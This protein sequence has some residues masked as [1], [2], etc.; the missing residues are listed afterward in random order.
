MPNRKSTVRAAGP[1]PSH[2]EDIRPLI[3]DQQAC[4]DFARSS[5]MEWI[6]ANGT[7]AFAMGTVAGVNTRGYH[8]LLLTTLDPPV[9]RYVLLSR[10]EEEIEIAGVRYSLGVSQHPGV[11]APTGFQ[12]LRQFRLD[13]FPVWTY[14]AGAATVTKQ[15]FMVENR[16]SIVL[17]YT[18]STK[19]KLSIRPLLAFRE[20]HALAHKSDNWNEHV[21]VEAN[22]FRLRPYSNLPELRVYHGGGHFEPEP[23]WSLNNEYLLELERGMDFLEDLYSPGA[24]VFDMEPDR[25]VWI[26]ATTEELP[27]IDD[28]TVA[29]LLERERSRRMGDGEHPFI[30]RLTAAADQFQ[31]NRADGRPTLLAGF[32]WFADW[33]RDSMISIPGLLISRGLLKQA[34]RIVEAFLHHLKQGLIPNRFAEMGHKPEYDTA[35]ATLWMFYAVWIY[36]KAGGDDAFI[37]ETF[38][39][40]VKEILDWHKR[41]T[42][43]N[44]HVDPSDSL[45]FAGQQGMHLTWMDAKTGDRVWTPRMGKPVEIQALWYNALKMTESWARK[46][47]DQ[48]YGIAIGTLAGE[49]LNNF[50]AKFWNA[51]RNC[52][53][54]VVDPSGVPDPKLRPNQ[55]FAVSLPFPLLDRDQQIAVVK[56]VQK[57]LLTPVGLR[58]LEPA[59]PDYKPRYAGDL[60]ARDSAYHQGTVWPYLIGPF[61][62]AYLNAF[63]RGEDSVNYCRRLISRFEPELYVNGLGTINEIYD[64]DPPHLPRG[65]VGQMWSVAEIL[66]A[67]KELDSLG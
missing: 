27:Q 55:I 24:V 37:R 22:S 50:R 12:Y 56:V 38:Y 43:F 9:D 46:Y 20:Y 49:V 26:L 45:L 15:F 62:S 61:V 58:S 31:A 3:I 34:S 18:C 36:E 11:V 41:G 30:S 17:R 2:A 59:D 53:Y 63:G 48:E 8:S 65:C 14:E 13:P 25:P 35:D 47:K 19:A 42:L 52:L 4:R 21:T 23:H 51:S 16:Q 64:G 32:P 57:E 33:G 1:E 10:V 44:I 7:G 28:K 5:R 66:R 39:P 29:D 6:D 60:P 54:D 67:A 40:K